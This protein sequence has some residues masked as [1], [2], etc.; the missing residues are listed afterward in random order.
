MQLDAN[1]Q[2]QASLGLCRNSKA[3]RIHWRASRQ[4]ATHSIGWVD[5]GARTGGYRPVDEVRVHIVKP[6][7]LQGLLQ[8]GFH[9]LAPVVVVPELAGYK[10]VVPADQSCLEARQW[11]MCPV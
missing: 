4:G 6:Q 5:I 11:V 2:Q 7:I 10:Q 8:G 9:V 1:L 3:D